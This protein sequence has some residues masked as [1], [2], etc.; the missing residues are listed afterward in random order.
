MLL[1]VSYVIRPAY[2][3]R[4]K[5][6]SVMSEISGAPHPPPPPNQPAPHPAPNS[7]SIIIV[8]MYRS[9]VKR[10]VSHIVKEPPHA[11]SKPRTK[12][13]WVIRKSSNPERQAYGKDKPVI[14]TLLTGPE[15]PY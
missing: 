6:L 2:R 5:V 7:T 9:A 1:F 12:V 3:P 11:N 8:L 13:M 14:C 4:G 15:S 10:F